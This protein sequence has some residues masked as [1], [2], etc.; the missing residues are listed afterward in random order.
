MRFDTGVWSSFA[1]KELARHSRRSRLSS[2]P[3]P[4]HRQPSAWFVG[5]TPEKG[6][7]AKVVQP[8]RYCLRL[9]GMDE[10][11]VD[12][13]LPSRRCDG[14]PIFIGLSYACTTFLLPNS[15][16]AKHGM[17]WPSAEK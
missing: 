17:L 7:A 16:E 1:R 9:S 10:R 15:E 6:F 4:V 13:A 11:A 2:H 8:D 12:A 5:S 14:C 3:R